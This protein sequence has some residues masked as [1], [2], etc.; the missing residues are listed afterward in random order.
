[1]T[2]A[3]V[4]DQTVTSIVTRRPANLRVSSSFQ[5][6]P[7]TSKVANI[8]RAAEWTDSI[9][10][11]PERR[12]LC[13]PAKCCKSNPFAPT[14]YQGQLTMNSNGGAATNSAGSVAA[15]NGTGNLL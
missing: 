2:N 3:R 5:F 12:R 9:T 6:S 10:G 13:G 15:K 8:L 7:H 14:K 4:P 1:M 11:W